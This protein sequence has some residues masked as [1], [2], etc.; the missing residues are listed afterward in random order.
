[1]TAENDE[2]QSATETTSLDLLRA[3]EEETRRKSRLREDRLKRKSKLASYRE[4]LRSRYLEL[5]EPTA[6][7]PGDLVMW[8]VGMKNRLRPA[9][10]APAIVIDVLPAPV[11]ANDRDAGSTDYREPL[12]LVLGLLDEDDDFSVYHFDQRRFKSFEVT[13]KTVRS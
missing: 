4:D 8:K 7:Q 5:I 10:G 13:R 9:E 1:L 12:D 2:E 11:F 3:Y 6:F